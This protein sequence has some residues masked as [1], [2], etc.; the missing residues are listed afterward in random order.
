M[1]GMMSGLKMNAMAYNA[2]NNADKDLMSAWSSPY[3]TN[4]ADCDI[5]ELCPGYG[6]SMGGAKLEDK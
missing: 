5:P 4:P 6:P 3:S 1:P 2:P